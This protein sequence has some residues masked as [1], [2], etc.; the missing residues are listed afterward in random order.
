MFET[1]MT[2]LGLISSVWCSLG[3]FLWGLT[4]LVLQYSVCFYILYVALEDNGF[5]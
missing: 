3:A 4:H 2:V 1:G 5:Q